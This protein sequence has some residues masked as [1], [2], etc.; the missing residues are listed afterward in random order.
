MN[1]RIMEGKTVV[2]TGA[3]AGIGAE[4]A[5]RLATLGATV[6]V[7][8]RSP[9]K[10]AAVARE[11]GAEPLVADFARLADVRKLADTLLDRYPRIDVLANN[12]GVVLSKR[13]RTEDGH[14][15]MFQVNYLAP[16][17]L[18]NLLLDRLTSAGPARVISTSSNGNR[19]GGVD[20][21]DIE[22]A[23]KR[24]EML[25]YGTTKLQ[26]I[27]FTRELARRTRGSGLTAAAFHPGVIPNTEINRATPL[28]AALVRNRLLGGLSTL[29]EGAAPLVHLATMPDPEA[30]NGG[31]Y[32]RLKPNGPA[33]RQAKDDQLATRLWERTAELLGVPVA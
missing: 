2:I 13:S 10:T 27:L 6:A 7:V 31:Y 29:E 3:S 15:L 18:T 9:E 5:R 21:D 32:H 28:I 12:A 11:V 4:A 16:F 23:R 1:D 24:S 25:R 19:F 14:D 20:I 17:L 26:N 22:G 8:G 33:H 30:A